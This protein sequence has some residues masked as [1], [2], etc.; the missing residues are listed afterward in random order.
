MIKPIND[1]VAIIYE[2]IKEKTTS[3]GIIVTGRSAED[4]SKPAMAIVSGVGPNST[5]GVKVGDVVLWDRVSRGVHGNIHIVNEANLLA[6]VE[7]S[8]E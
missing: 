6:I 4:K 5:V 3:S 2:E 8:E 1:N 7:T